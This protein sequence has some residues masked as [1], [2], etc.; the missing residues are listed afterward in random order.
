MVLQ[1]RNVRIILIILISLV[2]ILG[3]LFIDFM[4]GDSAQYASISI[5]MLETGQFLE[6]HHHQADYLDKPPL[7]FW[8]SSLSFT[9]FGIS[10]FT[11]RLPSILFTILGAY[12]TYRLAKLY[13]SEA[14]AYLAAIMLI[15][16]QA[17]FLFN[18]DVRTDTILA[19]ATIFAV[20]QLTE[21]LRHNR[22]LNFFLGFFGI[23]LAM[24]AK[25][26]I[27]IMVPVLAIGSD[28][29]Y[30]KQWHQLFRWEWII[31]LLLIMV[32]LGPMMLGLYRQFGWDGIKFYFWTQSFGRIT[33]ESVWEDSSGYLFFTHTFVWAF[34]PWSFIA[35]YGLVR[36]LTTVLKPGKTTEMLTLGGFL[37]PFIALSFSHFK[38]PHYIN[39]TFPFAAII[40]AQAFN[41]MPPAGTWRKVFYYFYIFQNLVLWI[42]ILYIILVFFPMQNVILWIIGGLALGAVI[43]TYVRRRNIRYPILIPSMLTILG[44]NFWLNTHFYP[45][46]QEY[47]SGRQAAAYIIQHDIPRDHVY[48]YKDHLFSMDAGLEQTVPVLK[49]NEEL[50]SR[51]QDNGSIWL[52]LNEE[53]TDQILSSFPEAVIEQEFNHFHI[54]LMN[55]QF[56]DPETRPFALRKKYLLRFDPAHY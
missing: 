18:H 5:E 28:I 48:I 13:Y 38:L 25:G 19:G 14:T 8:L 34:L 42:G 37:L 20:W 43:F 30:R 46:L 31:G 55:L 27:G 16:C 39:I 23:A 2:Y 47:Q 22:K 32:F 41:S 56:L 51:L 45:R 44:I 53:N 33:G 4:E 12:S 26:P 50:I 29:I 15:T 52:F 9:L 54:T 24:L 17:W 1:D 40:A 3:A 7:I 49:S 35:I 11:F 21:Y 36:K 10:P 6:V